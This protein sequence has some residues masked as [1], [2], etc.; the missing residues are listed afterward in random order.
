MIVPAG[1]ILK[2]AYVRT[3]DIVFPLDPIK[4]MAVASVEA[5]IKGY[6]GHPDVEFYPLPVVRWVE[7]RPHLWD[8]R[9]RYIASLMLGRETMLV[10][11]TELQGG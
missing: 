5:K 11:W 8:G 3:A 2:S 1:H 6:T 10:C 9:H 7:D 4:P